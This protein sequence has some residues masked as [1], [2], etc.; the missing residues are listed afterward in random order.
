MYGPNKQCAHSHSHAHK[1]GTSFCARKRRRSGDFQNL[2]VALRSDDC[3]LRTSCAQTAATATP[4]ARCRQVGASAR[5]SDTARRLSLPC[6]ALPCLALY[7]LALC[8]F[9]LLCFL[10]TAAQSQDGVRGRQ[11]QAPALTSTT[12]SLPTYVGN[13]V[14]MDVAAKV[15]VGVYFVSMV[16]RTRSRIDDNAVS[17]LQRHHRCEHGGK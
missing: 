4:H 9:V 10:H 6:F 3:E 7:C 14:E 16:W 11:W 15:G 13:V 12:T 8:C 1:G 5:V 2:G 17:L